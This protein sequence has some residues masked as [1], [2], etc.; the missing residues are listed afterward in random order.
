MLLGPLPVLGILVQ[1]RGERGSARRAALTDGVFPRFL[2]RQRALRLG[3]SRQVAIDSALERLLPLVPP[4]EHL[5]HAKLQLSE[6]LHHRVVSEFGQVGLSQLGEDF[7]LLLQSAP[8]QL[9]ELSHVVADLVVV[10]R[11]SWPSRP[12]AGWSSEPGD[13]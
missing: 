7:P 10:L 4:L 11:P 3:E 5:R 1:R 2:G 6:A 8:V 12:G 13:R 9:L